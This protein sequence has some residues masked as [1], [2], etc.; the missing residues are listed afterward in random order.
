LPEIFQKKFKYRIKFGE[1][2]TF[3]IIA[4][5]SSQKKRPPK[6]EVMSVE[7]STGSR[8]ARFAFGDDPVDS[9]E[10]GNADLIQQGAADGEERPKR[11]SPRQ[12]PRAFYA[13]INRC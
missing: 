5:G 2:S 1:T 3:I 6:W 8:G 13:K 12:T 10:K 7:K 9:L 4:K 11:K